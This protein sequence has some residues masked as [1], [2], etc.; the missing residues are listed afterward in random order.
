MFLIPT[1]T[2][3]S[4]IHRF[5]V[6]AAAAIEAGTQVWAFT[7]GVDW[8]IAPHEFA[9]FPEPYRTILSDW[10]YETE[11]GMY[12]LCGDSAKFMNHSFAPNCE[13]VAEGTFAL[14]RIEAG[15]ELTCDYRTF[16]MRS[17]DGLEHWRI[18]GAGTARRNGAPVAPDAAAGVSFSPEA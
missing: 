3:R 6:F 4:P 10:T 5:G 1:F 13:D 12:V 16:D 17:R 9:R 18:D 7:A 15:E 2:D 14:R 8:E 11:S